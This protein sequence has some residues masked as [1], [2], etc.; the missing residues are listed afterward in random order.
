MQ[1]SYIAQCLN[2]KLDTTTAASIAQKLSLFAQNEQL[3]FIYYIESN[4][5]HIDLSYLSAFQKFLK[6]YSMFC[7]KKIE[8]KDID[9]D[10]RVLFDKTVAYFC[11]LYQY[12]IVEQRFDIYADGVTLAILDYFSKNEI[13]ILAK[14]GKRQQLVDL[15]VNNKFQLLIRIEQQMQKV[16]KI[17]LMRAKHT[18]LLE[19]NGQSN[20]DS[21]LGIE[22]QKV[23]AIANKANAHSF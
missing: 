6:L 22:N 11:A 2:I 5:T 1:I 16:L 4:I 7:T 19:S 18:F 9:E 12:S 8:S 21:F 14:I 13:A 17:E 10:A 15:A 23:K 20:Q 3:E